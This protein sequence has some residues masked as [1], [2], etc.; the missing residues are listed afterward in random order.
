MRLNFLTLVRYFRNARPISVLR[1][2]SAHFPP[3]PG[4]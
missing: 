3:V 4:F 2:R 1:T